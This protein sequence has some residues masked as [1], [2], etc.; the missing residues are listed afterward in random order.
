MVPAG[1]VMVIDT[2]PVDSA[3]AMAV[4]FLP[5]LAAE[6]LVAGS[7]PKLTAV[8]PPRSVP[9]MVTWV[10]PLAGPLEGDTVLTTGPPKVN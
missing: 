7:E 2:V 4:I 3:G 5:F 6:K 1:V 9:A 8:A 10:P